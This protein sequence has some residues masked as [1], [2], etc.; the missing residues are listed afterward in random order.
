MNPPRN[1]ECE[2]FCGF[3]WP[4]GF[5]P[6]EDCPIHDIPAPRDGR[7]WEGWP[8]RIAYFHAIIAGRVFG[9]YFM[10]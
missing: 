10:N 1:S 6:E 2:N 8:R 9:P 4:F 3:A 5:V 7:R